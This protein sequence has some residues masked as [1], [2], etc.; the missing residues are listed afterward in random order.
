LLII[1]PLETFQKVVVA[2]VI[3][4][5]NASVNISSI[6]SFSQAIAVSS[7]VSIFGFVTSGVFVSEENQ[8]HIH[9]RACFHQG[10]SVV[11]TGVPETVGAGLR[12]APA[13]LGR[14]LPPSPRG[15]DGLVLSSHPEGARGRVR[16]SVGGNWLDTLDGDTLFSGG[17]FF[18][19]L[20]F[21]GATVGGVAGLFFGI[22]TGEMYSAE[23][24]HC[25]FFHFIFSP[26]AINS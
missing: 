22:T 19:L 12:G 16:V 2:L 17:V 7:S 24:H 14:I 3:E 21:P 8:L 18:F 4:D 20:H 9:P 10:I 25:T 1:S 26:A 5:L 11:H 13:T 23:T 6:F 15:R